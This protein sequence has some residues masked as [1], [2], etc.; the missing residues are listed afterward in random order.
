MTAP[1]V[2]TAELRA[3]F[4]AAPMGAAQTV[5]VAI[6]FLLSALDGYDVLSA[7]FAAPAISAEWGLGKAA[8]GIVLAAGLAGMALGALLLAPL[9]DSVGR[10]TMIVATLILMTIGMWGCA[11]SPDIYWLA[12]MRVVTGLG[13]GACVA[14][15]NPVAAEF[16]NA[17]RRPLTVAVMAVG[18][19]F[20][21]LAGGLLASFLLR[22]LGWPA[23]FMA[24]AIG[25][26]AMLPLVLWLLP[27]S[28]AY[29]LARPRRNGL[30]RLNAVLARCGQPP[31][32]A[33]EYPAERAV[34]YAA[35]FSPP[36]RFVTLWLTAVNL[37]YVLTAYYVLSW[38]PQ[39][40]ADAGYAPATASLAS[41]AA[42]SAGIVGGLAMGLAA[43]GGQL[44]GLVVAAALG[45]GG[46]TALLGVVPPGLGL[47][48]AASAV[49]GFF[50]F[51]GAAGLYAV[52]A[53]AFPD[54]AR[55]TGT[56]IVSGTGRIGSAIAPALAGWL[57]AA[58][59]SRAEVSIAF[60][61]CAVAAGLALLWGWNRKHAA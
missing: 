14:V 61:A 31:V 52:I 54:A 46:A 49:C 29:L 25:A 2:S 19:P 41:V 55:A 24:G 43:Q 15:I 50:L 6:T 18:F 13:I 39:L 12:S 16:A 28:P 1:G 56:G 9:A 36:V 60:A 3:R 45:L 10:K 20:G 23:V 42:S 8:L 35:A 11:V 34:G 7:T 47:L 26:L 37:L 51:A 40:V 30:A 33:I 53:T 17:R 21:G 38:L 5:A 4:D 57:F 27:E 48:L 59:L 44:R 22:A 32:G 58:G